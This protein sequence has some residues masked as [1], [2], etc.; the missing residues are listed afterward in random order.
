MKVSQLLSA[1]GLVAS[2]QAW[3]TDVH[4][5]YT[6]VVTTAYETY[7]PSPTTF[8][9]QNVTY[10]ATTATTLTITNCPCT[11]TTD[12]PPQHIPTVTVHPPPSWNNTSVR[13][14]PGTVV[15]PPS[16]WNTTV[17]HPPTI[18]TTTP[19]P[20]PTYYHNT[21]AVV[22]HTPKPPKPS[23]HS[24]LTSTVVVVEPTTPG[25]DLPTKTPVGPSTSAP[26]TVPG[27]G[28]GSLTASAGALVLA[29]IF[30]LLI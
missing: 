22:E 3:G 2:T 12:K 25:T 23:H 14:P 13:P 10:T 7:C 24:N 8:V 18:E 27:S 20:K 28:A 9:H 1:A 11:I 17:T 4:T 5:F 19:P 26:V 16:G 6:T 15:H 21:S 30:A 29:G